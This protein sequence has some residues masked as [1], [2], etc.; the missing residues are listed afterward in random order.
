MSVTLVVVVDVV[1][2]VVPVAQ[3]L[4]TSFPVFFSDSFVGASRCFAAHAAL[5]HAKLLRLVAA[6]ISFFFFFS[7]ARYPQSR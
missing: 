6:T 3:I 4:T 5:R 7:P 2:V 1:V